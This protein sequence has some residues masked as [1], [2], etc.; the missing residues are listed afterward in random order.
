MWW[1]STHGQQSGPHSPEQIKS[2]TI[3]QQ[4]RT[5]FV[6][7]VDGQ[8]WISLGQHP[9]FG[10]ALAAAG[11]A[12]PIRAP[13][14]PT[15]VAPRRAASRPA[16]RTNAGPWLVACLGLTVVAALVVAIVRLASGSTGAL[17]Q[18][19]PEDVT[20]DLE[21]SNVSEALESVAR[22]RVVDGE[23]L[24]T[25]QVVDSLADAI[26]RALRVDED[27]VHELLDDLEWED[28]DKLYF[29]LVNP[30]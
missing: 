8:Q 1:L 15:T 11:Q 12:S 5:G 17:A 9:M 2:F 27:V 3:Y 22:M 25:E 18:W 19:V 7:A 16:G 14:S 24:D 26:E 4:L 13:A 10:P 23:R 29:E 21:V 20:S 30:S 6:C 28:A